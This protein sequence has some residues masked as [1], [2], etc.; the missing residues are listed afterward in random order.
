MEATVFQHTRSKKKEKKNDS[1]EELTSSL[2]DFRI[3]DI[4]FC[5]VCSIVVSV[6][7]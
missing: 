7:N 1:I 6:L 5:V 4:V 3:V 2:N